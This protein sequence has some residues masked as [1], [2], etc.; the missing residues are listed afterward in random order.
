MAVNW[1][2]GA[3]QRSWHACLSLVFLCLPAAGFAAATIDETRHPLELRA[4]VEPVAVLDQIPVEV[5]AARRAAD[6]RTLA[7]LFLAQANAC[8]VIAD[9]TCQRQAGAD[10]AAAAQRAGDDILQVRGLIAEARGR[11][12][13][14]DF[15]RGEHL[16]GS[17][18]L[19]L[20]RTPMAELSADVFLAY[21]SLSYSLGK[22]QL[23]VENADRGLA[24]LA[25][26]VAVP[27]QVRL[28]RNRSR[29][30]A[31]LKQIAEATA[32]LDRAQALTLQV[33]DPKLNAELLLERARLAQSTGDVAVQRSSAEAVLRLAGRLR[34]SQLAGLGHEALGVAALQDGR[35]SEGV[36]E[37]GEAVRLYR[38]LGQSKDE[39]R[40]LRLLLRDRER[41][42]VDSELTRF[43]D[44]DEAVLQAERASA[45]DDFDARVEYAERSAD[46]KRLRLEAQH[47]AEREQALQRINRLNLYLLALG[48]AVLLALAGFYLLQRGS[49]HRLAGALQ[50]KQESETRY[51]I[52][53][54]NS[55]DLVVRMRLDG[56]R[57]YVS[58]A[59]REILGMEPQ[60]LADARWDLTHPDDVDHVRTVIRKLFSEGGSDKVVFRIRHRDGEYRWLEALARRLPDAPNG[61]RE[62]VYSSRDISERVRVERELERNRQFLRTVTDNVPALVA[63][64][65]RDERFRFA[66]AMY[67][68]IFGLDTAAL[69]GK[70]LREV[71]GEA[72]YH[73]IRPKVEAVLRGQASS[74][75]GDFHLGDRVVRYLA[76]FIPD[77]GDDGIVVGFFTT[78]ID[79]S[80]LKQAELELSRQARFDSLTGVPNRRL[81]DERLALS[82]AR[83]K[84]HQLPIALLYVDIDHFKKV[85]D[86]YGHAVGDAVLREVSARLNAAVRE[87]DLVARLGGDEF[88]VLID[89]LSSPADAESIARK[90]LAAMQQ[91]VETGGSALQVTVSIGIGFFWETPTQ[92]SLLAAADQALYDA[93]ESGRN[94][95]RLL[96]RD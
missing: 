20:R 32:S 67:G 13:L 50:Q 15:S 19:L 22:H 39:L 36:R 21:S 59:S 27:M 38:E 11:I 76:N 2:T 52:L 69:I 8:R 73:E 14:Q 58:P 96:R 87:V 78:D 44:L 3:W 5:A 80:A 91:P 89:D 40:A 46:L 54:E 84:R 66:N 51:R 35:T 86:T 26:G 71:R 6:D 64:F 28:L 82:L 10:A 43:L 4:L 42:G 61:E 53:A 63:Y 56:T 25:P 48:L 16:L 70:T 1:G 33:D 34:N 77:L 92:E 23:A 90:L 68:Q 24:V 17:A 55:S 18:Q 94:T 45:A 95:F 60:E 88:V 12:S 41:R 47:G 81:L 75:E 31:Y 93:K 62:I 29:A 9:W 57:T 72:V 49:N 37:L 74:F 30:Q 79:I 85:N 7:R 83:S 65:D